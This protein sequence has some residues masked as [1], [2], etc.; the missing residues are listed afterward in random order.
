MKN[1]QLFL[2]MKKLL[3]LLLI[4]INVFAQEK[5]LA[6]LVDTTY[7]L[8]YRVD[9]IANICLRD[10]GNTEVTFD[11]QYV[12]KFSDGYGVVIEGKTRTGLFV[13]YTVL[14]EVDT[15]TKALN[16]VFDSHG[17]FYDY[18]SCRPQ[19]ECCSACMVSRQ[20]DC[21]CRTQYCDAGICE[22]RTF[23]IMPYQGISNAVR[24][25]ILGK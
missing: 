3:F 14:A 4:P 20:R 18:T 1:L 24:S 21:I 6:K 19:N 15:P 22:K 8:Q 9:S 23:G 7:V 2:N 11:T 12:F 10:T 13:S 16:T 25:K 5:P 17:D